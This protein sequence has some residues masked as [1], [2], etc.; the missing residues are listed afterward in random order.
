[1]MMMMMMICTK[2]VYVAQHWKDRASIN[3]STVLY[4]TQ[5]WGFQVSQC[6]LKSV[7][8]ISISQISEDRF[9]RIFFKDFHPQKIPFSKSDFHTVFHSMKSGFVSGWK[10]TVFTAVYSPFTS[11]YIL[12]V[13]SLVW[14]N[15]FASFGNQRW[16]QNPDKAGHSVE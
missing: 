12:L 2:Y 16:K 8:L 13:H 9:L 7:F 5:I 15:C 1:M 11:Q 4:L 3:W 6:L 10:G 14:P